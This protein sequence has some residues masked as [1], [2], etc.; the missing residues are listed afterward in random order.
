MGDDLVIDDAT[1]ALDDDGYEEYQQVTENIMSQLEVQ[2]QNLIMCN[3][4]FELTV[5]LLRSQRVRR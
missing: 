4:I 1:Y 3:L 2:N 5:V